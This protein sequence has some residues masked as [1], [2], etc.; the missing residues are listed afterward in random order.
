MSY[1]YTWRIDGVDGYPERNGLENV[2]AVV[3]WTLEVRW[4][5]DGSFHDVKGITELA[6]PNPDSFTDYLELSPDEILPW[7]WAELEGGKEGAEQRAGDELTALLNPQQRLQSL[8]MPWLADCCPDGT[9]F[10]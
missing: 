8:D 4:P 2:A 1:N 10:E 3:H 7:V 9:G 6:E 5:Q